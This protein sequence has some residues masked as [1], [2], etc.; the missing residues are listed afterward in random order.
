MLIKGCRIFMRKLLVS[1]YDGTFFVNKTDM[2]KNIYDIKKFREEGN[3]FAFATGNNYENFIK[4]VEKN[5]IEYDYL[6]L[7]HGS[8]IVDKDRKLIHS[9]HINQDAVWSIIEKLHSNQLECTLCSTW[10]ANVDDT[11]EVTKISVAIKDLKYAEEITQDINDN[12]GQFVNAYTMI[13]DDM[14]MVE[15]ISSTTDK[16]KA[17]E[18]LAR[19]IGIDSDNIYTI[20]N[21]YNDIAMIEEFNG[22]CMED[23]VE[24]LLEECPNEVASVSELV[25]KLL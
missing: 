13:F 10:K 18:I 16:E 20:G 9:C 17:I 22:Y 8:V 19:K 14:N 7:D 3:I 25:E 12:Y 15:V 21:G 4:V 2:K 11:S 5:D 23:S 24:E 1:D 6:L